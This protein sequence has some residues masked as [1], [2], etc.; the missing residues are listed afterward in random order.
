MKVGIIGT[1]VVAQTLG[2]KLLELGHDVALGTR[3]PQKLDEKKT[4]AVTL[5]EWLVAVKG[6]ARVFTFR[7]A[8]VH[9]ELLINAT[10]GEASVEALQRAEVGAVGS[11]ILIDTA[12]DLD[13]GKGMPP[14]SRASQDNCLAEKIQSA[15]PDLRVVKSLNTIGAPVMVNPRAV[16]GGD[17]TVFV[18]G[19]DPDAKA[20]VTELLKSFGWQDVMDL[21]DISS[22]RGPEMY[23]A[24]WIRLW[25][26][27]RTG[28]INVRVVR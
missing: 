13:Y 2:S 10:L 20:Q 21:G 24:M 18:S 6:R 15:F 22:A 14:R 7:D 4:F 17:H 3:D 5:R 28:L 16:G 23:M 8:A 12:N 26:A 19:N 11:K 27:T 9:G 25:G 1:G